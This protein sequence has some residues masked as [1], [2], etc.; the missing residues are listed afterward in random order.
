MIDMTPKQGDSMINLP[1]TFDYQG[2]RSENKKHK[3]IFTIIIVVLALLF[4]GV[5][6]FLSSFE[7]WQKILLCIIVPYLLLLVLRFFIFDE[8]YYSD[9]F[10]SLKRKDYEL[11]TKDFWQ[12]FDIDD[13]YPYIC[14]FKNGRKGI[15]VRMEKGVVVG[16]SEFASFSHYDSIGDAYNIAHAFNMD[17]VPIDYMDNVGNDVRLQQLYDDLIDVDNPDMR[18]MLIDIY[19][20]L[21]AEMG[22][23]YACFDVY[24]FLTRDKAKN[25]LYNVQTVV[26]SMLGGNFITYKILNRQEISRI[27]PVLFNFEDFSLV[28]ACDNVLQNVHHSG[29][30]PLKVEHGDGTCEV[31]GKTVAEKKLQAEEDA[32]KQQERKRSKTKTIQKEKSKVVV[33]DDETFDLFD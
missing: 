31:L 18:D 21:G 32:R 20:N 16:K 23:S 10:E 14:Y 25:F 30:V 3:I 11:D 29:I 13:Y 9:Q 5:V 17:I 27:C 7:L 24:L 1:I 12:I 8:S 19:D 28:E 4:D 26:G 15:F 6:I 2:G 33:Q 22:D